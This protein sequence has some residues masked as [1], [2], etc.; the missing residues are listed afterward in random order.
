MLDSKEYDQIYVSAHSMI[1]PIPTDGMSARDTAI[2]GYAAA[3]NPLLESGTAITV[4]ADIPKAL[5]AG[6][7][8]PVGCLA[9]RTPDECT[10]SRSAGI[11]PDAM[12]L[13][14]LSVEG[15]HLI[16]LNDYLCGPETCA[17]VIGNALVYKDNNH[18]TRTYALTM[19]PALSAAI[20]A[21]TRTSSH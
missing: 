7:E 19:A 11:P 16:D 9:T 12:S 21:T 1:L 15:V 3:W 4:I 6:L 13:A 18:L 17:T 5:T 20:D 14:A 10:F 8:D 2:D